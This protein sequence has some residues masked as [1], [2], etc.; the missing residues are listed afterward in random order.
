M[1]R[2]CL[3]P[4]VTTSSTAIDACDLDGSSTGVPYLCCNPCA[5]KAL[6]VAV[7]P[8]R[9]LHLRALALWQAMPRYCPTPDVSTYSTA[10]DACDWET[11]LA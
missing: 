5:V 8:G 1:H 4:D 10:I 11:S 6:R 2:H 9:Q 3:T 7:R